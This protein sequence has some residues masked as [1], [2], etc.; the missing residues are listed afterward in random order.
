LVK[1]IHKKLPKNKKFSLN[2]A[3]DVAMEFDDSMST[4]MEA[5]QF[6]LLLDE[7]GK[8]VADGEAKSTRKLS[9]DPTE[10]NGAVGEDVNSSKDGENEMR[11]KD[12]G[13]DQKDGA[14]DEVLRRMREI[15]WSPSQGPELAALLAKVQAFL[16]N[17]EKD[18][19]E[20]IK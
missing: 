16:K 18:A 9:N 4:R 8:G 15:L 20:S 3:L 17:E 1:Y 14:V 12:K 11:A 13:K 7:D 10:G 2:K 6:I 5:M 19:T